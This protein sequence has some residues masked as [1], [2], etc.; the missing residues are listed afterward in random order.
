LF[1][2]DAKGLGVQLPGW[3]YPIVIDTIEGSLRFD[4]YNGAWGKQSELD[5]FLQAYAVEKA[6]IEARKHGHSVREESLTDGS[7]KLTIQVGA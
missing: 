4:N 5:K 7:I 6:T 3:S 2:A 1:N